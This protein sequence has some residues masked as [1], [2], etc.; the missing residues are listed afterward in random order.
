MKEPIPIERR[1]ADYAQAVAEVERAAAQWLEK[2]AAGMVARRYGVV[3]DSAI[4]DVKRAERRLNEARK[5][6][7]RAS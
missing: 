3:L 1:E 5:R 2:R 4:S 6:A 7:S